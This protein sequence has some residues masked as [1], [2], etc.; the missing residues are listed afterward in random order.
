M[1]CVL[2]VELPTD[3]AE[4]HYISAAPYR[5][6]GFLAEMRER[7]AEK[8]VFKQEYQQ[9]HYHPHSQE[10]EYSYHSIDS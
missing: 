10:D 1:N 2:Q 4:K 8:Q 6:L 7:V 3:L 9:A 5:V